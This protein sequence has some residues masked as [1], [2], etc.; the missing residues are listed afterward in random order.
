MQYKEYSK[1][2]AYNNY[3]KKFVT[4]D[5]TFNEL[6]NYYLFNYFGTLGTH[7]IIYTF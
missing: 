2:E 3:R 5:N 1:S 4:H 6:I 7:H